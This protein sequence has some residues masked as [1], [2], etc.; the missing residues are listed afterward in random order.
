[1]KTIDWI[2]IGYFL[3]GFICG[4]IAVRAYIKEYGDSLA[5]VILFICNLAAWWIAFPSQMI[6]LRQEKKKKQESNN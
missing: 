2:V 3:I 6:E 4:V 5:S 1:M